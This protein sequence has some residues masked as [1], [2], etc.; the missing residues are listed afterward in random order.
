MESFT[1][2]HLRALNYIKLHLYLL[3]HLFHSCLNFYRRAIRNIISNFLY[4]RNVIAPFN[5]IL[6][7]TKKGQKRVVITIND[8][9]I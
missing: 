8:L 4:A 2:R 7:G 5:G 9:S 3:L 1:V 6:F